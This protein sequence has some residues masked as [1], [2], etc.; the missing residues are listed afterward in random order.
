MTDNSTGEIVEEDLSLQVGIGRLVPTAVKCP[1]CLG[2]GLVDNGFYMA[3]AM[4][5]TSTD[6][7]PI[8][9]KSCGGKGYVVV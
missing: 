8:K 9:C 1:V 4:C 5:F 7:T 6:A 2:H 3:A